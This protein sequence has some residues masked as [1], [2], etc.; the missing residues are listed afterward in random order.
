MTITFVCLRDDRTAEAIRRN[1]V[2][3]ENEHVEQH[4]D[5]CQA[6]MRFDEVWQ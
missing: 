5:D 1:K 4:S 6:E 3:L 2:L